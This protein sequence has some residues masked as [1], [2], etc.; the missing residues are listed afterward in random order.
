MNPY[1]KPAA[2]LLPLFIVFALLVTGCTD[3]QPVAT[4][5][6]MSE[7]PVTEKQVPAEKLLGLVFNYDKGEIALTVVTK[8]CTG[9]AD[10]SF[11]VSDGTITVLRIK[12]DEC[13]AMPE[14]AVFLYSMKEL[15]IDPNKYYKLM[16][17]FMANPDLA[18]IP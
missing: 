15:G 2:C 10:F 17:G 8:G 7:K 3:K 13:K 12:K 6:P 9:K 16:N 14:A 4:D 18:N 1:Y 5:K 11:T